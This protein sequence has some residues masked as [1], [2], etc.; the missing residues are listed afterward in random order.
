MSFA[1]GFEVEAEFGDIENGRRMFRGRG[2]TISD[3][4]KKSLHCPSL[5]KAIMCQRGSL[6]ELS[7]GTEDS[8]LDS[9][10]RRRHSG[11][12]IVLSQA[13]SDRAASQP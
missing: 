8:G 4:C 1:L 11:L 9:A 13:C 6:W 3:K 7:L 10:T 5:T 2:G 12:M